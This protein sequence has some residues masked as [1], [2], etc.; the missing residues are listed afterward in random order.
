MLMITPSTY[1]GDKMTRL[2]MS[3]YLILLLF[4]AVSFGI[5]PVCN[6]NSAEPPS[7]I[8]IV[9]DAPRDLT[10]KI[11]PDNIRFNRIDKHFESYYTL[12]RSDLKSTNYIIDVSTESETFEIEIDT[13]L[14][15]Y[16]NLYS[17]DIAKRS[18]SPGKP[19]SV[20]IPLTALRII[21]TLLL[22]GFVFFIFGY[23]KLISWI[24]FLIVNVITQGALNLYLNSHS[25]PL[26]ASVY[27]IFNLISFEILIFLFEMFVFLIVIDEKRRWLTA[28]YVIA[29]NLL[30][31][32]LGGYLI[33]ILPI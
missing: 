5:V 23:R 2:K 18:L 33:T 30:S 31:L 29:A 28:L 26:D 9:P 15:S 12:Y 14:R 13:P 1:Q 8:I 21:L 7:I 4:I 32:V 17:L 27:I 22:E 24:V 19:L 10:I 25:M 16:N 20:V 6:A 3:A 11:L